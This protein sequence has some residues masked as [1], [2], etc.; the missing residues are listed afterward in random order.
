MKGK[1]ERLSA[2]LAGPVSSALTPSKD[3]TDFD[4]AMGLMEWTCANYFRVEKL[5]KDEQDVRKELKDKARE[6]NSLRESMAALENRNKE[7]QNAVNDLMTTQ[8]KPKEKGR[9][10]WWQFWKRW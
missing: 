3:T 1:Q 6:I 5:K 8:S 4:R 10:R 9:R 7:L 2:L